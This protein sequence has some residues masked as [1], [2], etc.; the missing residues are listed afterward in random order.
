MNREGTSSSAIWYGL[1]IGALGMSL[2]TTAYADAECP[3]L[4]SLINTLNQQAFSLSNRADKEVAVGNSMVPTVPTNPGIARNM[5]YGKAANS[6]AQAQ[7]LL[8]Q[9]LTATQY[10]NAGEC[11][12]YLR[13]FERQQQ[14]AAYQ[15]EIRNRAKVALT[16][17]YQRTGQVPPPTNDNVFALASQIGASPNEYFIVQSVLEASYRD[18]R[19]NQ[20][21]NN[22]LNSIKQ[23]E[24]SYLR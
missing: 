2:Q 14:Q 1:L 13:E 16:S 23:L 11:S 4:Q 7:A 5:M 22:Q 10:L 17:H 18:F 19:S 9:A 20:N 3:Q 8:Q 12:T 21:M 15:N 6:R 24:R